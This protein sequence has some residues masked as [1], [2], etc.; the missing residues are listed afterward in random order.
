MSQ[1]RLHT[2]QS[3]AA[4]LYGERGSWAYDMWDLINTR[5]WNGSLVPGPIHWGLTAGCN[6]GWFLGDSNGGRIT[7]HEALTGTDF[8]DFVQADRRIERNSWGLSSD[9]FGLG[10]ALGTLLHEAM[11]QAHRQQGLSYCTDRRGE[12][13]PHHNP[14][15]LAECERVAPLIGLPAL[16]WPL[17]IDRKESIPEVVARLGEVRA[18][19]FTRQELANRRMWISVPTIDGAE[20]DPSTWDGLPLASTEEICCFP[21]ATYQDMKI[22][23]ADRIPLILGTIT[24]GRVLIG[25]DGEALQHQPETL[26]RPSGTPTSVAP[27]AA[28]LPRP[29]R[30]PGLAEAISAAVADHGAAWP[31]GL[32][33]AIARQHGVSG[34]AVDQRKRKLLA[35]AG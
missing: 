18:S 17:Y 35:A 2:L 5:F 6:F 1:A 32:A 10:T 28:P 33:A 22:S 15:W 14:I 26:P 31:R 9:Y 30:A 19:A 8:P 7:I 34:Q 12:Y 20:V 21:R 13:E 29:E 3:A 4:V 27:A 23:P 16:T 11:H 25:G 24:A